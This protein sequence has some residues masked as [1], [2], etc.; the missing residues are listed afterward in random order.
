MNEENNQLRARTRGS[1]SPQKKNHLVGGIVQRRFGKR[2]VFYRGFK[3]GKKKQGFEVGIGV[4]R[5]DEWFGF[6]AHELVT[7]VSSEN[8]SETEVLIDLVHGVF[9]EI[10]ANN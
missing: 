4:V 8:E 3:A 9:S 7:L 10:T 5:Q 2:A 1:S 6:F